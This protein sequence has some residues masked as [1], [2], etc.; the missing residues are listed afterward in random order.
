MKNLL[1]NDNN[2]DE[3]FATNFIDN[4]NKKISKKFH[5]IKIKKIIIKI[6]NVKILIVFDSK[7]KINLINNIFVKKFKLIS[8][9][10]SFCEIIILNHNQ[11]KFYEIYFVRLKIKNIKNNSRFFNENFLKVNLN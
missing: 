3:F 1:T 4:N 8:I 6:N 9:N 2:N 10:V 7:A 5:V 11:F